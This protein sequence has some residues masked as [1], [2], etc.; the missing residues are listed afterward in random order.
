MFIDSCTRLSWAT[1]GLL[2]FTAAMRSLPCGHGSL[3]VAAFR[4]C[5][6]GSGLSP[7]LLAL[8][9]QSLTHFT[10]SSQLLYSSCLSP[11]ISHT[12]FLL[13][14]FSKSCTAHSCSQRPLLELCGSTLRVSVLNEWTDSWPWIGNFRSQCLT[15]SGNSVEI[16][17]LSSS[18]CSITVCPGTDEL[19]YTSGVGSDSWHSGDGERQ[20]MNRTSKSPGGSFQLC[21]VSARGGGGQRGAGW[22][23]PPNTQQ[24][25]C[26]NAL[27]DPPI[28]HP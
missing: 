28:A 13:G 27:G 11:R 12:C 18:L 19:N 16:V 7:D 21:T 22:G 25:S 23:G 15:P 2:V 26:M 8:G 24:M 3:L 14:P 9:A 4:I 6:F 1:Q 20:L 5:C 17:V 10:T